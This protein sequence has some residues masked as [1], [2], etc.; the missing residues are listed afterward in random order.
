V[1]AADIP[2][3]PQR[4]EPAASDAVAPATPAKQSEEPA[5]DAGA[6]TAPATPV[7]ETSP[8]ASSS[9]SSKQWV[10]TWTPSKDGQ[11]LSLIR[12]HPIATPSRNEQ[13][14]QQQGNNKS[15][16]KREARRI[17]FN[18]SNS[19]HIFNKGKPI[20]SRYQ[21]DK[22]TGNAKTPIEALT[23]T[24][25]KPAL[26][27][28]P[29]TPVADGLSP[30]KNSPVKTRKGRRRSSNNYPSPTST[31]PETLLSAPVS[32]AA[33]PFEFR[34]KKDSPKQQ[35]E[36]SQEEE[37]QQQPVESSAAEE[38]KSLEDEFE[39][40]EPQTAEEEKKE[41]RDEE[42]EEQVAIA[43]VAQEKDEEAVEEAANNAVEAINSDIE[44][45]IQEVA[46]VERQAEE[47]IEAIQSDIIATT[48]I[49]VSPVKS[50][51]SEDMKTPVKTPV[52]AAKT[53]A[54][55][56]V[57]TPVNSPVRPRT[58]ASTKK[59]PAREAKSP[60]V[61]ASSSSAK[62]AAPEVLLTPGTSPAT[63]LRRKKNPRH[64]RS[65]RSVNANTVPVFPASPAVASPVVKR[66]R[67]QEEEEQEEE[68]K[69]EQ[70]EQ[71]KPAETPAVDAV[72]EKEAEKE[73]PVEVAAEKEVNKEATPVAD[74][75]PA[76]AFQVT[77]NDKNTGIR[78]SSTDR[79]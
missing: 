3:T 50:Q 23:L 61:L 29:N 72:V 27:K 76:F 5:S 1:A 21:R 46:E 31:P 6:V 22:G 37:Q 48:N 60:A 13:Q 70:Q 43:P 33:S 58:P 75:K 62:D 18:E 65:R 15:L 44:A 41:D 45:A 42:V 64:K 51:D 54:K 47:A 79:L 34:L 25:Q 73:A 28:V 2:A 68:P 11:S 63:A 8:V 4:E 39:R 55:T 52:N 53:P 59:T 57:K 77:L 10:A 74:D 17:S 49:P 19:F 69:N 26:K 20:V 38:K 12:Y 32:V 16:V 36:E 71:E 30:V 67:V 9:S 24:P 78:R 66:S 35:E 14:Q 56:P 7:K 40:I